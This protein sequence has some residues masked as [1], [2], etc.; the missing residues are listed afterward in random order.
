MLAIICASVSFLVFAVDMCE[1]FLR[2][3]PSINSF[4]V[5]IWTLPVTIVCTVI[6]LIL[7]GPR[8][9][10]LAWFA[11]GL[12]AFEFILGYVFELILTHQ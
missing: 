8:R 9:C 7:V 2:R 1:I 11:V 3:M 6:A 12:F 10:K 5:L 4:A